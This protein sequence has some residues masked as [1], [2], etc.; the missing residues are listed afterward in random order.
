LQSFGDLVKHFVVLLEVRDQEGTVLDH[1]QALS[2]FLSLAHQIFEE[3][4]HLLE[5]ISSGTEIFLNIGSLEHI[6]Q[7]DPLLLHTDPLLN[8]I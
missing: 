2:G 1:F 5:F 7:V 3:F 6:L 4:V 8:S